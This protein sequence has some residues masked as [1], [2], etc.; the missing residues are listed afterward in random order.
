MTAGLGVLGTSVS[1]GGETGGGPEGGFPVVVAAL[2]TL[3]AS[4]SAW[5]T[6]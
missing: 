6:V 3:P 1:D 5:V 4:T 2:V